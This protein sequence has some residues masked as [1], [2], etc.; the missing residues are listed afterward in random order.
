MLVV[1]L[2]LAAAPAF[3]APITVSHSGRLL[4]GTGAPIDGS[5]T[6]QVTMYGTSGSVWTDTFNAV[7]VQDGY[8]TV[9]LGSG[10]AL[11]SAVF[12]ASTLD[13]AVSIGGTEL[14]RQRLHTAPRAASV[15]GRVQ[16]DGGGTCASSADAGTIRYQTGGLEYC[17]GTA[18]TGLGIVGQG[19]GVTQAY[20]GLTCKAIHDGYPAQA[21]GPY[22]IDPDGDTDRSDAFRVWCDME[23]NGG[24][25]TRC[26]SAGYFGG[27]KPAGWA[28]GTWISTPWGGANKVLDNTFAGGN[29]GN[30]CPLLTSVSTEL[31]GEVTYDATSPWTNFRTGP[32]AV[33][34]AFFASNADGTWTAT[35]GHSV[36]RDSNNTGVENASC[37]NQYT[38]NTVQGM[39]S[40]CFENNSYWQAQHTGWP[41]NTYTACTDSSNQPCYCAQSSYCGGSNVLELRTVMTV[42]LR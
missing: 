27:A 38:G 39:Q 5:L 17:N 42:Y 24:G 31:S 18:W 23:S 21:S 15:V 29:Y 13:V 3:A 30:F 34:T 7:P 25:W 12:A 35:N 28:K 11:D 26:L 20:A 36:G 8:F 16:V 10:A 1:A 33:S 41:Q 4:T 22:W 2:T 40:M 32:I 37:S 6:L 14:T 19:S 9:V